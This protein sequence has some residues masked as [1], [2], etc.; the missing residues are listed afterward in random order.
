MESGAYSDD[1]ERGSEGGSGSSGRDSTLGSLDGM[2]D[3]SEKRTA[4]FTEYS[5]SSSVIPRSEGLCISGNVEEW[6]PFQQ[7]TRLPAC[8]FPGSSWECNLGT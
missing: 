8:W 1:D 6:L 4:C 7:L 5:M 2:R 3:Q